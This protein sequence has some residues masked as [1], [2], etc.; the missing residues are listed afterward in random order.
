M[1]KNM[2][3]MMRKQEGFTLVELIIVIVIIGILVAVLLPRFSGFTDRA[4]TTQV[5]LEGKNI[6]TAIDTYVAEHGN[7][8][9][10]SDALREDI[11]D[12]AFGNHTSVASFALQTDGGF[13]WNNTV[14]GIGIQV[15]RDDDD[16]SVA[17]IN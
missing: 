2:Q 16:S 1:I 11:M 12:V 6:A 3:K 17:V 14:G 9:S 15:G 7:I 4:K 10:V 8:T 5:L 13:T